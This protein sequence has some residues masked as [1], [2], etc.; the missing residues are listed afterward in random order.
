MA[1]GI[2]TGTAIVS[3]FQSTSTHNSRTLRGHHLPPH[4]A[5]EAPCEDD[6]AL[7]AVSV[8]PDTANTSLHSAGDRGLSLLEA[9][10]TAQS[11]VQNADEPPRGDQTADHDLTPDEIETF[12]TKLMDAV[13]ES[14]SL[15]SRLKP[16]ASEV[17]KRLI[18]E[19]AR[20]EMMASDRP[21]NNQKHHLM[22]LLVNFPSDDSLRFFQAELVRQ[23]TYPEETRD[24]FALTLSL[25]GLV[26]N[27][28]ESSLPL[29]QQVMLDDRFNW[30]LSFHAV[31]RIDS[32][33]A[34]TLLSS[35]ANPHCTRSFSSIPYSTEEE[36]PGS[37][38][39]GHW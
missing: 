12:L 19:I 18:V 3:Y 8:V 25:Y 1:V 13:P 33:A 7:A 11:A 31:A 35:Y 16:V 15:K 10:E 20:V 36:T 39:V 14:D 28:S 34:D 9:V 32:P 38:S 6:V 22:G 37:C 29:L 21:A 26:N 4:S 23:L 27:P 30:G 17:A 2:I 24:S 5:L